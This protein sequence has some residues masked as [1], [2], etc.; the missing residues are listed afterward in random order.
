MEGKKLEAI[1]YSDLIFFFF[2]LYFY[3]DLKTVKLFSSQYRNTA[4]TAIVGDMAV[5]ELSFRSRVLKG[6]QRGER[7]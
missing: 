1:S 5:F 4:F 6:N 7:Q 3:I 2:W